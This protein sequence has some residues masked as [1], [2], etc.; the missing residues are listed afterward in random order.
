MVALNY[1]YPE[2]KD[3]F[4][5]HVTSLSTNQISYDTYPAADMIKKY[6]VTVFF[7]SGFKKYR[8]DQL[9][10]GLKGGSPDIMGDFTIVDCRTL[11]GD[12][13][14][15]CRLLSLSCSDNFL[16]WLATKMKN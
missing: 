16:A 12:G 1:G 9:G 2:G 14:Q 7:D 5:S 6:A 11:H 13:H 3:I 4:R 10:P 15:H 8:T